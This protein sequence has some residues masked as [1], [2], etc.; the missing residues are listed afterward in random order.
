MMIDDQISS[1]KYG[2]HVVP[3]SQSRC[4]SSYNHCVLLESC[5][6][7]FAGWIVRSLSNCTKDLIDIQ[8]ISEH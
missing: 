6:G 7:D 3:D 4:D 1:N 5:S 2:L 8:T